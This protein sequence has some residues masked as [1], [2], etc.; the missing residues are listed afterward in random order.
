MIDIVV[1]TDRR[2]I[3]PTDVSDYVQ[4]ILTEDQLVVDALRR[5]GLTVERKSWDD[6]DFDWSTTKNI[7]FR[8]TWDYFDRF[9]EFEIWL[10]HVSEVTRLINQKELIY[11]NIDKHYLQDLAKKDVNIPA[12]IFIEKGEQRSLT[13][14]IEKINWETFILKPAISGAGRHTYKF[15]K[16]D[17]A[18]LNQIFF[19]LITN[20]SLLLQE[21][22]K[23]ITTKGEVAFM[24]FGGKYSHA[25]LKK[26]KPG[27]FRVQ[28]DFGGTI[29][30]YE[31][32]AD[33]IAFI[34]KAFKAVSP[35]PAYARI[36]VIWDNNDQLCIG[37]IELIE[38]EL[39]FRKDENAADKFANAIVSYINDVC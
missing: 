10:N 4:N 13:A 3:A 22:Q 29:S 17:E 26:A 30:N 32:S 27:D 2:Y 36:D 18:R 35:T 21:Y 19:E 23:Q 1:L 12:T 16:G 5:K 38:P 28:D 20:E 34:E 11:W 9:D 15:N 33:E 25:I 31:P 7:L 6:S 39:W 24:V 8:T 14:C 37:E